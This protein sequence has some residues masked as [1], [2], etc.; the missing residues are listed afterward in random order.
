MQLVVD[1][2]EKRFRGSISVVSADNLASQELGG[3]KALNAALRKC[4]HCMTTD[5]EM[6]LKVQ[7]C[8]AISMSSHIY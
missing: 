2:T 7:L 1:G 5:A 6:Q 4:R 3:F 8:I